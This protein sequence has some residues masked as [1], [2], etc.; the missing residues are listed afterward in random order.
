MKPVTP[1]RREGHTSPRGLAPDEGS[2]QGLSIDRARR[3]RERWE[4]DRLARGWLRIIVH[5]V[6]GKESVSPGQVGGDCSVESVLIGPPRIVRD[7]KPDPKKGVR[8]QEPE[9]PLGCCALLVS[10]PL[11]GQP[12]RCRPPFRPGRNT[13]TEVASTR[14]AHRFEVTES[15]VVVPAATGESPQ[16]LH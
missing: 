8:Q 16:R 12:L 1:W 13:N 11:F 5:L 4:R 3:E 7:Q 9:R 14:H 2:P 10:A 6:W 15:S